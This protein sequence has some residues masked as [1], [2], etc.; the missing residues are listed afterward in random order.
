MRGRRARPGAR[1]AARPLGPAVRRPAGRSEIAGR[2]ARRRRRARAGSPARVRCGSP[3]FWASARCSCPPG[4]CCSARTG[5]Y[6]ERIFGTGSDEYRARR[7]GRV[8]AAGRRRLR[9][10]TPAQLDLSRA[11]VVVAVPALARSPSLD[12][13][14]AAPV[15]CAACGAQGRCTKRVVVVGRGGA[16]L[17]LVEPAP[18]R[19]RHAGL[20]VVAACVTPRRPGARRG[21]ASS[22]PVGGLDDVVATGRPAAAP[23]PSRSPRPARPPPSTCASC[24]GSSRAPAWSC[25]SR[26]A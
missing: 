6:A 3:L 17:E 11:L 1:C 12:R 25:S 23:T 21:R 7:S 10:P 15:A 26:P 9:S 16:V 22:L 8:A 14:V 5:A 13:Y 2:R 20:D 24:P 19:A 4:R 18:A